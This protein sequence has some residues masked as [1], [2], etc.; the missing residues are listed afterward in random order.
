MLKVVHV[1]KHPPFSRLLP[2]LPMLITAHSPAT[3]RHLLCAPAP[4]RFSRVA[5]AIAGNNQVGRRAVDWTKTR[6]TNIYISKDVR[7]KVGAVSGRA[8]ELPWDA[9]HAGPCPPQPLSPSSLM[10]IVSTTA[11]CIPLRVL[12][13]FGPPSFPKP[14]EGRYTV[15]CVPSGKTHIGSSYTGYTNHYNPL[16]DPCAYG[17]TKILIDKKTQTYDFIQVRISSS[18][19]ARLP[20]LYEGCLHGWRHRLGA[21]G[22]V[23]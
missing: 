19:A 5:Y 21:V 20:P 9:A 4:Q 6:P 13:S 23:R 16:L 17:G 2:G 11:A 3:L 10:H 18:T 15:L 8:L 7:M 12:P 1:A 22:R 14:V